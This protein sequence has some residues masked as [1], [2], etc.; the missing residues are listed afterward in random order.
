MVQVEQT[1]QPTVN[2]SPIFGICLNWTM[3][4]NIAELY[5]LPMFNKE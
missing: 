1:I 2:K 3:Y 4:K 5:V